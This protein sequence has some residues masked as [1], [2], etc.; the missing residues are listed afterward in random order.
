MFPVR[1]LFFFC[2][3]SSCYEQFLVFGKCMAFYCAHCWLC[4]QQTTARQCESSPP[5]TKP[6]HPTNPTRRPL[7]RGTFAGRRTQLVTPCDSGELHTSRM[8]FPTRIFIYYV[9]LL[10]FVTQPF[11]SQG[12]HDGVNNNRVKKNGTG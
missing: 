6:P 11:S 2:C 7:D 12:R 9:Y 4:R 3:Q 1:L 8:H 10:P 5:P